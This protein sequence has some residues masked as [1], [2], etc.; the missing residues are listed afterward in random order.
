MVQLT[1]SEFGVLRIVMVQIY[2]YSFYSFEITA[3]CTTIL[4]TNNL[5]WWYA[6]IVHPVHCA[7][8]L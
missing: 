6:D 2:S 3:D 1:T 5:Y 8:N 7:K 4:A